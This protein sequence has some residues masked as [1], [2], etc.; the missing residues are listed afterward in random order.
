MISIVEASTS[1][2]EKCRLSTLTVLSNRYFQ[3]AEGVYVWA[4]QTPATF[5]D[6]YSAPNGG[7]PGPQP[8]SGT[9]G[10]CVCMYILG[11]YTWFDGDCTL[12]FYS[13]LCKRPAAF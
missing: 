9:V 8:N 2:R 7:S 5:L 11:D 6:W 12:P 10:N 13:A 1:K 3:V 4:D